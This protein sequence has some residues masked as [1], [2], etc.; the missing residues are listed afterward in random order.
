MRTWPSP[1]AWQ[2]ELAESL[3]YP[4]MAALL[5]DADRTDDQEEPRGCQT[6]LGELCEHLATHSPRAG[7]WTTLLSRRPV[8]GD[9]ATLSFSS[10]E[11]LSRS[12]PLSRRGFLPRFGDEDDLEQI[13][14][15]ANALA[16]VLVRLRAAR[17]RHAPA[18]P[19]RRPEPGDRA[20]D[21]SGRRSS[22][23]PLSP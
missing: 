15:E 2:Q 19:G 3:G 22:S 14:A 18:A 10:L 21:D 6:Y 9:A 16:A 17:P 13:A 5:A 11:P 7:T 8:R 1:V 12:R 4:S 20:G 23:R